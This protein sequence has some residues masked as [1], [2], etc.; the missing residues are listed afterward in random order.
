MTG[1]GKSRL[2]I[3]PVVLALCLAITMV[4]WAASAQGGTVAVF[5]DEGFSIELLS[6]TRD[7]GTILARFK[8]TSQ[9]GGELELLLPRENAYLFGSDN[10]QLDFIASDF[11]GRPRFKPGVPRAFYIRFVG[12]ENPRASY[13]L[14]A[15]FKSAAPMDLTFSGL[16]P[17]KH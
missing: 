3:L 16:R 14:T 12:S 2:I 8:A 9:W 5:E 15:T 10:H 17:L 1:K 6:F 11:N 4:C 7:R 13:L